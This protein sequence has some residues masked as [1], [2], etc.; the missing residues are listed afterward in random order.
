MLPSEKAE[1]W[2]KRIG[3]IAL[4]LLALY[5]VHWMF[6]L[7][8]G[9]ARQAVKQREDQFDDGRAPIVSPVVETSQSPSVF[10]VLPAV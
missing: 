2:V 3:Y 8:R 4:A 5:I 7:V 1:R 9:T 10:Y 6:D